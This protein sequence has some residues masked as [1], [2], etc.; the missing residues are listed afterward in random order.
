MT[1]TAY[2]TLFAFSLKKLGASFLIIYS[3]FHI[4]FLSVTHAAAP[5]AGGNTTVVNPSGE[6][7]VSV[8]EDAPE[9]ESANIRLIVPN[10][11]DPDGGTPSSIRILSIT[12]GE[13]QTS[14][15]GSITLGSN[16]SILNLSSSRIDLR[17]KPASN[18]DTNASFEYVV[19]DTSDSS[20]NSSA[21][22]ATITINAVND[23]PILQTYVDGNG[24]GLAATYYLTNWDLTGSTY[25]RID[26]MVNFSDNFGVPGLNAEQFSARWT[27]KVRSPITGNITFSTQSDDGVRLWVNGQ[28]IIDNWTLHGT[29]TDTASPMELVA[30]ELY[31]IR[32]EFYERGGGEVAILQWAYSGQSTQVI[33][34]TFLYPATIRPALKFINGSNAVV[35]DDA[36]TIEDVDSTSMSSATVEISSNYQSSEDSLQFTN[37]NG[38]TGSYSSGTLTLSGTASVADYQTA[39]RSVRYYN[40]DSTPTT[41]T[42]TIRFRVNDG[43]DNSNYVTRNIEF[44]GEN[45]PPVITQGTSTAV[46]MDEDASP[47]AFSLTLDATDADEHSISWSISSQASHGTASV[48]ST[49]NSTSV[50]YTPDANYYGSD[51]F[52]VQA[53]DGQGGTDTITVNVTITDRTAPI[54]SNLSADVQSSTSAIITW[55]TN[56]QAS[57]RVSYGI[58]DSYGITTSV[59]DTSPRVTSHS[60]TITDLISCTTYYYRVT[61]TDATTNTTTSSGQTF[62]TSGC[63]ANTTPIETTLDTIPVDSG[64]SSISTSSG[65]T[66]TVT[67]PENATTEDD[68]LVIQIHALPKDEVLDSLGRPLQLPREVG[69]VV[70][71]VKAIIN[72]DTVL[73][74]FDVPVT[75]T[76]QYSEADIFGLDVSTLWLYHYTNNEWKA[77]DDCTLDQ[78]N[79]TI[80]CTTPSFSIFA[81]FAKPLVASSSTMNSAPQYCIG[82][83]PTNAPDLFQISTSPT[84]ATVYFVPAKQATDY[85]IYYGTNPSAD[86]HSTEFHHS[87]S[88][89]VI[90]Y[91]VK[92]LLPHTKYYFTVQPKNGCGFG[93]LSQVMS[94]TTTD[95][96]SGNTSPH[97]FVSQ[98]I[99]KGKLAVTDVEQTSTPSSEKNETAEN[100]NEKKGYTVAIKVHDNGTPIGGAT[101]ELHSTPQK[102]VTDKD[103]IARFENVERGQHT[104]YLSYDGYNGEEKIMLE[105]DDT[106]VDVSIAVTL[107]QNKLFLSSQALAIIVMLLG[108]IG[109]LILLLMKKKKAH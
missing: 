41:S 34:Q 96:S 28:Q 58:T 14:G 30:G 106:D 13:L 60:R 87:D 68:S 104:V 66:I 53:S 109:I 92:D 3:V 40:S 8:N 69:S 2:K 63:P 51:S 43:S 74:S 82:Q 22:T 18:R 27:G 6:G 81:L 71:D 25:S 78:N 70:F 79:K 42:R 59:T 24:T 33:P 84:T 102:S 65:S 75:I 91:E 37:Q 98:V 9:P 86:Q 108:I 11:V 80:S 107:Q 64:G 16:G 90:V 44:T 62:M 77:L 21:S 39:L 31:D 54:I 61:S 20:V 97:G 101:V 100:I 89:G 35:I 55:T 46:T 85:I 12:G 67:I 72:G 105:G 17:F 1:L 38:I 19:V 23:T 5:E 50:N 76:Y 95:P 7:A 29:T 45:T 88:S 73:D 57:T 47:T 49:G 48:G 52:V 94:S 99:S 32:M 15:G 26:S 83:K 56:E 103:G 10:L 36:L 93:E 4:F